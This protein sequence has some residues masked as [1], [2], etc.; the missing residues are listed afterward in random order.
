MG[1]VWLAHGE[2]FRSLGFDGALDV[3]EDALMDAM[4]H[5]IGNRPPIPLRRQAVCEPSS[6][7][8]HNL[9][10]VLDEAELTVM[11]NHVTVKVRCLDVLIQRKL[12]HGWR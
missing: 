9:A 10:V 8:Q 1:Y 3:V 2:A 4:N 7:L 5:V 6:A 11:R 12:L